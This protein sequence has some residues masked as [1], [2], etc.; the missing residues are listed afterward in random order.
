MDLTSLKD[1]GPL[2]FTTLTAGVL[3]QILGPTAR[4]LG[5]KGQEWTQTAI[6]NLERILKDAHEKLSADQRDVGEVPPRVLRSA[7]A[8]GAFTEDRIASSYL[9]GVLASSKVDSPRDDRGVVINAMIARLSVFQIRLHYVTYSAMHYLF[10]GTDYDL[11]SEQ[12]FLNRLYFGTPGLMLAMGFSETEYRDPDF[13]LDSAM[14]HAVYGLSKEELIVDWHLS[15]DR[16]FECCS[17]PVGIE[18]F[19]WAHGKGRRRL[20]YFFDRGF[21]PCAAEGISI[22]PGRNISC[23]LD[24]GGQVTFDGFDYAYSS[25]RECT[26]RAE[27][28]TEPE[29]E[30]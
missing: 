10:Q 17:T 19:L 11:G 29:K 1:L 2:P 8:E 28:P 22:V 16:G 20:E 3:W 5:G 9:G 14:S 13:D 6:E 15:W 21:E 27:L 12:R 4:Y 26:I 23:Q 7:I 24:N 18:L 30:N 25:G